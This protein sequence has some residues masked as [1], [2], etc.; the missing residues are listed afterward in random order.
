VT[1]ASDET[2]YLCEW[3]D[4]GRNHHRIFPGSP[5][6]PYKAVGSRAAME[7]AERLL[8]DVAWEDRERWREYHWDLYGTYAPWR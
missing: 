7:A 1:R 3:T 2:C 6:G 4:N 8:Y 5:H